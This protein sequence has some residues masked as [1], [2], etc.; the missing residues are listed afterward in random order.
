[1][2]KSTHTKGIPAPGRRGPANHPYLTVATLM[3]TDLAALTLCCASA[4]WGYLLV[5]GEYTPSVYVRLWPCLFLFLLCY[6]VGGLYHGVA[7]YPG[8]AL[9]PAEELRRLTVASTVAYLL[10]GVATFLSKSGIVYS[11]GVFLIAWTLSIPAVPAC[12]AGARWCFA[13]S[14]WWGIPCVIFGAGEVNYAHG[15]GHHNSYYIQF[16]HFTTTIFRVE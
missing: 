3:L 7:L 1:M 15:N 5:R 4:V 13:G 16:L 12:R 2:Q 14:R 10:L 8:V 11:R 9:G 6:E